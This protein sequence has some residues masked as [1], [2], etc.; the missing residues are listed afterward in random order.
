M[1]FN[2]FLFVYVFVCLGFFSV[3]SGKRK[4]V[5]LLLVYNLH[6]IQFNEMI[7]DKEIHHMVFS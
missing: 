2:I 6:A 3:F 1:L 4:I 7:A 5:L